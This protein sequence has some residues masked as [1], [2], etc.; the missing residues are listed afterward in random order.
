MAMN[1]IC[2]SG[3]STPLGDHCFHSAYVGGIDARWRSPSAE[4]VVAGALIESYI[5]GGPTMPFPEPDGTKI[6]PGATAPGGWLRV[7][8][9]G[10]KHLL[11]SA[12]YTGAGRQLQYN[13]VGFMARQNVHMLKA[14]VGWRTLDPGTYTFETTSALEVSDNRNLSGLDLGQ[15]YRLN[16]PAPAQL[17]VGF[18]AADFAPARFDDREVGTGAA[19]RARALR[20]WPPRAGE[21][22]PRQLFATLANQTQIIGSGTY[23]TAVQA[24]FIVHALRQLDIRLLPR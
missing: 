11:L 4:Y 6:G 18:L 2:P 3:A 12:E 19:L 13:D 15:L 14:S 8:K 20:R 22:S 1:Q 24:S 17:L 10:G 7:A 21:R 5:Q 9:E 23:A 16:P